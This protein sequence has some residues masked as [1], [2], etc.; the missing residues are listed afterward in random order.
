MLFQ[1]ADAFA[2]DRT[3]ARNVAWNR[4][5]AAKT[6]RA[7]RRKRLP[8][9]LVEGRST[10]GSTGPRSPARSSSL[11]MSAALNAPDMKSARLY[12]PRATLRQGLKAGKNQG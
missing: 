9:G 4:A 11:P 8:Y 7:R 10:A 2:Y 1:C 12:I 6:M 3:L 5:A